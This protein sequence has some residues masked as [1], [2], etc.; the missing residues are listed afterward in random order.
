[1]AMFTRAS[2]AVDLL[3]SRFHTLL[4]VSGQMQLVFVIDV[5]V[6]GKCIGHRRT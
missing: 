5:V 4:I 1:M 2:V 3:P 6:R